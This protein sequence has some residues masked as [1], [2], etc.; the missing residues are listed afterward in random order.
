MPMSN[1]AATINGKSFT[2][3]YLVQVAT[4][5]IKAQPNPKLFCWKN[6]MQTKQ[7]LAA[8]INSKAVDGIL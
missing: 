2:S 1:E 6:S 7:K 4:T 5:I 3:K 8:K